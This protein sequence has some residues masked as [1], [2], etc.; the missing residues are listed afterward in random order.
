MVKLPSYPIGPG[1]SSHRFNIDDREPTIEPAIR[2][3]INKQINGTHSNGDKKHASI[4]RE[5]HTRDL[6]LEISGVPE[7]GSIDAVTR[8]SPNEMRA[9]INVVN[10]RAELVPLYGHYLAHEQLSFVT[11][12]LRYPD[13]LRTEKHCI[14]LQGLVDTLSAAP[15]DL[16]SRDGIAVLRD[17]LLR[18]IL[19]PAERSLIEG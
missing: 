9:R 4:G 15:D 8:V 17:E 12:R 6:R 2:Q 13:V 16:V 18:L 19:A 3:A 14:L 1:T 10:P 11:P 5:T 7:V